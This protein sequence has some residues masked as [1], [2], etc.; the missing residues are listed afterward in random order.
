MVLIGIPFLLLYWVVPIISALYLR[1][2]MER[3]LQQGYRPR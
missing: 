1:N 2:E 3:E